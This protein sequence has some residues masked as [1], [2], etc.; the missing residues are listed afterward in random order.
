MGQGLL[1]PILVAGKVSEQL[2]FQFG[3][4]FNQILKGF[5]SLP[6]PVGID[7]YP[8][9]RSRCRGSGSLAKPKL[10]V[11]FHHLE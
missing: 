4:P 11:H 1:Y 7:F 9:G 8:G 10:L 5:T 6:S 2:V 3:Y